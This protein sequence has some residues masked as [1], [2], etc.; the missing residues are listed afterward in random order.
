MN[1]WSFTGAT[2]LRC[3]MYAVS[4]KFSVIYNR[5]FLCIWM[6][7]SQHTKIARK[8]KENWPLFYDKSVQP[9]SR[10]HWLYIYFGA[11]N[12]AIGQGLV[13]SP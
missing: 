4:V 8:K 13:T 7:V 9:Y 3:A 12:A 2:D 10:Q 6:L 1:A 11:N 5:Y